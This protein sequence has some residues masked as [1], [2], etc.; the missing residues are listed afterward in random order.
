MNNQIMCKMCIKT[1]VSVL[2][3]LQT[4]MQSHPEKNGSPHQAHFG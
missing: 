3:L 1:A 4:V 2:N